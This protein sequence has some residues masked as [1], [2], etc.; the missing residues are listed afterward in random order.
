MA[1]AVQRI[2]IEAERHR[3]TFRQTRRTVPITFSMMLVQASERRSCFGSLRRVTV[4]I[5][6]MPSRI[7]PE[8]PDK[9]RSRRWARF[10]SSFSALSASSSS[11]AYRNTRQSKRAAIWAI[12]P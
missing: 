2:A 3:F 10:R 8:T 7:E 6:S 12:A 5:S 11:Q 1:A 9:S 4:R